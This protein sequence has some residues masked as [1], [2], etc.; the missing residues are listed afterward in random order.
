LLASPPQT[1]DDLAPITTVAPPLDHVSVHQAIHQL[2]DGVMADL[3]PFGEH[4][5]RRHFVSLEAFDLQQDQV[6][7]RLHAGGPGGHLA[8]A[9]E[10]SDQ[11]A[12]IGQ[13]PIVER[14]GGGT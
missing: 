10:A 13:G 6:L 9:K 7:L 1:D 3:Q 12:K 8:N 14:G 5:H 4:A 11:I 2:N